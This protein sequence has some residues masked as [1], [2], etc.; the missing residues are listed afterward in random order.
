MGGVAY[1]VDTCVL[2]PCLGLAP[3]TKMAKRMSYSNGFKLKV[4][5]L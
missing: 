5:E 2:C 1:R 3:A 4:V